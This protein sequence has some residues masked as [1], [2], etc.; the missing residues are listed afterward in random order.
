M[1]PRL[2]VREDTLKSGQVEIGDSSFLFQIKANPRGRF[3]RITEKSQAA[4]SSIII[5]ATGLSAF[6]QVFQV[7]TG[8]APVANTA[9]GNLLRTQ[10][11]QI[12]RKHFDF[13]LEQ[14]RDG[15]YL[16]IIE[17]ATGQSNV[18]IIPAGGL[19][20]FKHLLD[21]MVAAADG[22]FLN[23][24]TGS[25][26]PPLTP[27]TEHVLKNG[28]VLAGIRTFTL[29]LKQNERGRF[30]RIIQEKEGRLSTIIIPAESLEEFKKWVVEIAKAA[31]KKPD[32]KKAET[33]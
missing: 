26:T 15:R 32:K 33:K 2:P 7:V 8:T 30:M 12:E 11:L 23:A 31:K 16:R 22:Q 21:E 5:P 6:Q 9:A 29:Q 4:F 24:G 25:V 1:P 28:Q 27:P 14:D 13:V 19:E 17:R 18:L 20:A 10:K 3:L